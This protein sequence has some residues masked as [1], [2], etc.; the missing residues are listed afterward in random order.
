M[1]MNKRDYTK[2][3]KSAM[4]KKKKPSTTKSSP[5][6]AKQK[7]AMKGSPSRATMTATGG[8]K[9]SAKDAKAPS[10]K[11]KPG[12]TGGRTSESDYYKR[13]SPKKKQ[14]TLDDKYKRDMKKK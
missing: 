7:S 10:R 9:T 12:Q 11:R 6:R 8:V 13:M 5:A 4:N 14:N 2:K 1:P 3:E